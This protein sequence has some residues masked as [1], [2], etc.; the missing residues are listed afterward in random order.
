MKVSQKLAKFLLQTDYG[1][2]LTRV[3]QRAKSSFIDSLGTMLAGSQEEAARIMARYVDRQGGRPVASIVGHKI[4]SSPYNA[5]MVN[6]T[7]AHIHDYDDMSS[8]LIGHPSVGVLPAV[9]ALGEEN[10][11]SGKDALLAFTLGVEVS[12]KIGRGVIP[13]HYE[14]GWHPTSTVGIFGATAA[15]SKIL[16]LSEEELIYAFGIAGSESSGVRENFGTMTKPLH[17]GRAA[18]KGIMAALLA[19]DGFTSARDIFGGEWGFCRVMAGDYDLEKITDSLGHP[20]EFEK[21]GIHIKPYPTCGAAH[22][23]TDAVISLSKEHDLKGE[24]VQKIEVGTVPI[25]KDVLVYPNPQTP[26]EAKFSLQ[27][28]LAAA[29]VERANGFAQ[30]TEEKV[31]DPRIRELLDKIEMYMAPEFESLGYRGTFNAI[32]KIILKDGREYDKR[33]DYGRG[34]PMNPLSEEEQ[35]GK[36]VDCAGL[37][38]DSERVEKSKQMLSTL[39][40]LADVALLM[41]VIRG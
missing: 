38:L 10:K 8:T 13:R 29:L 20:F 35:M 14:N 11:I 7:M 31:R 9:L 5:A 21:P 23:A 30:F 2:I 12:C 16:K 32:V 24:Q 18:A 37:L 6:G 3:L 41:D 39:E 27:Y 36:Y 28:C 25:A 26:L 40:Q 1:D 4:K 15:A 22:P 19:K 34:D 33:V 17:P